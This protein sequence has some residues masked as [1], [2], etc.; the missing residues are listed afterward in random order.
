MLISY[1]SGD[2]GIATVT[3]KGVIKGKQKG[4]CYIYVYAQNEIERLEKISSS[5][6]LKKAGFDK[7]LG[8]LKT[9]TSQVKDEKKPQMK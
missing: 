7:V 2:T 6:V 9:I 3:A 1:E 8:T 5:S 4:T